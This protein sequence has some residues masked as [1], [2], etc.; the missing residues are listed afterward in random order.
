VVLVNSEKTES[1][2]AEYSFAN[3]VKDKAPSL[4]ACAFSPSSR[5]LAAGSIDSV[6]KLWDLKVFKK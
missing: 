2:L 6:I 4:S 5:Y 1:K 3:S